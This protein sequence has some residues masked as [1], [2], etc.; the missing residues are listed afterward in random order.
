MGATSNELTVSS[1]AAAHAS[2]RER[3]A[4]RVMLAF[5][6][7]GLF[8]MVFPGTLLGVVNLIAISS[9]RAPGAVSTEWVQAHGHAQLFGW[10]G[11]FIIGIGYRTLPATLRRRILGVDEA[12]ISLSLWSSGALLRWL[13]GSGAAGWPAILPLA[14]L[15][16]LAGF[17]LFF[18]AS[19]G[20][21]P[22]G[23]RRPGSWA[24]VVIGGAAGF[25]I[26]LIVHTGLAFHSAMWGDTAAIPAETNARFLTLVIWGAVLPFVWGFTA[27]WVATILGLE[28]PRDW[29]LV[30]AYLASVAGVALELSG[31][32]MLAAATFVV[33][34]GWI[35]FALRIFE[36]AT[37]R[38]RIHGIHPSMSL[39][40]RM[41]YVWLLVGA[42]LGLWASAGAGDSAGVTGASRHA[43]TVGCLTTM[44]FSVA[45]R[46]LPTFTLRTRLFSSRLMALALVTLTVGCTIRV[47][48]QIL[49][50]Q[51]NAVRAWAWLPVSAVVELAAVTVFATNMAATFLCMPVVTRRR[52]S[53]RNDMP[54]PPFS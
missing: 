18:S 32:H 24:I 1:Q 3:A 21:R 6:A 28:A 53:S 4:S 39:F 14:A 20:H 22:S 5:A 40:V 8:F 26:A 43:L 42:G 16:E 35:I 45:P 30:A 41:A 37:G 54:I 33:A 19:L 15:L 47:A 44:V 38:P 11:T 52:N 36:R 7:T 25:L 27:R 50:Y 23:G 46:I 13:M 31:W 34:T 2:A 9:D 29:H 51:G 17:A 48:A 12:W 49:A 10:I